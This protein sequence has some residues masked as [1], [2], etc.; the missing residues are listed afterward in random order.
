MTEEKILLACL[1]KADSNFGLINKGD[2]ILLGLS[3]GKD[4]MVLARMLSIY[5]R[6]SD[7]D[8]SFKAIFMDLGFGTPDTDSLKAFADKEGFELIIYNARDVE[9]I[10]SQH[11]KATGILPCSICSRM[12]KAIINKAAH[13]LG[14][15]KVAFAHHADDAI[16]TLFMNMTHGGRIKTFSPAMYLSKE[17]ITFVR[18]LIYAREKDIRNYA[19]AQNIPV[20]KNM[21]GNDKNTERQVFK[22]YLEEFYKKEPSAYNNFLTML[23]N[24]DGFQLWFNDYGFNFGDNTKIIRVSTSVDMMECYSIRKDVFINGQNVPVDEEIDNKDKE[25]IHFLMIK[26]NQSIGTMRVFLNVE[27]HEAIFGRIAII[28]DYQLKG[29]GK[30]MVEQVEKAVSQIVFPLTI[31]L[32][33]QEH[34]VGFYEK[35]NYH[36]VSDVFLDA[37]IRHFEMEKYIEFP[38]SAKEKI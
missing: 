8:F 28:P 3:G 18:P 5:R 6:F 31:K 16:E 11:I 32:A 20:I 2:K 14:F 15:E 7:K 38:I 10:L 37:G 9:S 23:T 24:R 4:S 25:A 13:E 30:K 33:A 12:K 19:V 29:Y 34:A 22:N 27:K 36:K 21:C 17:K 35:L 26:N 1:R